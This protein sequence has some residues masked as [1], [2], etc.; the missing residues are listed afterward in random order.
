[1]SVARVTSVVG[2]LGVLL[3]AP[4]GASASHHKAHT[5]TLTLFTDRS[6]TEFG[7][8]DTGAP[9]LGKG[10]VY[11]QSDPVKDTAGRVVGTYDVRCTTLDD[12]DGAGHVRQLCATVTSLGR[13][14]QL[15]TTGLVLAVR[16]PAGRHFPGLLPVERFTMP[17]V[18]GTG[19]FDGARGVLH[20]R[21]GDPTT[22]L[23]FRYRL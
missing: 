6:A 2:A 9:G 23:R 13:R 11:I 18:G 16:N 7:A 10:D 8:V 15:V 21:F 5:K 19:R 20:R 4:A 14:S 3:L 1:V 17:I 22:R 12:D